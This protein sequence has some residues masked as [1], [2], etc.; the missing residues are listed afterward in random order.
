MGKEQKRIESR[1]SKNIVSVPPLTWGD[2]LRTIPEKLTGKRPFFL[3]LTLGTVAGGFVGRCTLLARTD[4]VYSSPST[5]SDF[6]CRN[7]VNINGI[8]FELADIVGQFSLKK[9]DVLPKVIV[10]GS[11]SSNPSGKDSVLIHPN[12]E[13]EQF[14]HSNYLKY[15]IKLEEIAQLCTYN[16]KF[17]SSTVRAN[18]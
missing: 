11:I 13:V 2:R 18:S 12:G 14:H 16:P 10:E 3:G 9:E 6:N 17:P 4:E 1:R 8:P 5:I 7:Y 15:P